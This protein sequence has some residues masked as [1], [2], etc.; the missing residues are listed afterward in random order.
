M[1]KAIAFLG[2][3]LVGA[4]AAS[5]C[6]SGPLVATL[7]GVGS[8]GAAT[9]LEAWRPYLLGITGVL[10]GAAFYFTYRKEEVRCTDG[11]CVRRRAPWWN[12][13]LLWL[14]TVLV[15]LIA[16]SPYY[17]GRLS[18]ILN[19]SGKGPIAVN[20]SLV[21]EQGAKVRMSIT[22]MTCPRCAARVEAALKGLA[23]VR[24]AIVTFEKGE[25]V[26]EFDPARVQ[27]EQLV[28]VVKESGSTTNHR[29][30]VETVAV[31]IRV[32]GMTC[33]GCAEA[34]RRELAKQE[35]VK[36]VE[37]SLEEK[38]IVVTYDPEKVA[39]KHLLESIA[40]AGF[41]ATL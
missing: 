36:S 35:G 18:A 41:A 38:R 23:G 40:R 22:G 39:A 26:I 31:T 2:A 4:G 9:V 17:A 15:V 5:L 11:T 1:R 10:L 33:A 3:S 13:A 28:E 14:V 37:V 32:P 7:L 27:I 29:F 30:T 20:S 19:R 6:C 25:A 24:S 16:A 8:L 12:Q 21:A 34:V